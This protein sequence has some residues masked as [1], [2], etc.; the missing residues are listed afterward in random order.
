MCIKSAT[1]LQIFKNAGIVT[2]CSVEISGFSVIQI[3]RE[4]NFEESRSSKTAVLAIFGA[5]N[6]VNLVNS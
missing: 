4:I 5:L 6:S 2:Q 1:S 3:L